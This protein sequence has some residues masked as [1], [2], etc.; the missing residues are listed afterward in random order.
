[1]RKLILAL[2]LLLPLQTFA[3]GWITDT[4]IGSEKSRKTETDTVYPKKALKYLKSYFKSHKGSS[5]LITGDISH[6]GRKQDYAKLRKLANKYNINL[7]LVRGNHDL[8][9]MGETYYSTIVDGYKIIV[10]DSNYIQPSGSGG[11]SSDE[12][13]FLKNELQTDLPVVVA[14][15]HSVFHPLTGELMPEYREFSETA[16]GVRYVLSGHIHKNLSRGIFQSQSSFSFN[17]SFREI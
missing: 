8:K 16:K 12:M 4:H 3:F 14:M 15:H 6:K 7:I 2:I 11:L 9:G 5:V 10:L 1:M 13:V 17:K